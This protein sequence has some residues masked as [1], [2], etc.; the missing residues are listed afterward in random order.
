MVTDLY[1]YLSINES[2]SF[3]KGC[4]INFTWVQLD[5]SSQS[6]ILLFN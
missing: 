1:E 2:Y 5:L 6:P 3:W 4:V